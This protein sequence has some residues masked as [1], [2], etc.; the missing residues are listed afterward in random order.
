MSLHRSHKSSPRARKGTGYPF[1]LLVTGHSHTGKSSFIQTLIESLEGR[2]IM[3]DSAA[4]QA[5]K[6][7]TEELPGSPL[8][9]GAITAKT[10]V[11]L[12]AIFP[13]SDITLPTPVKARID[14]EEEVSSQKISLRIID[15]P[16]LPIPV[17]VHKDSKTPEA[18]FETKA[19]MWA[20]SITQYI[21]AQYE[22]TLLEESKVRRNPKSPDYQIHAC[23]YLLDPQICLASRGLTAL[24][25][26]ALKRLCTRV[27]VVPCLGKADLLTSKQLKSVRQFVMDDIKKNEIAIFSFPDD[28]EADY[29]DEEISKISAELRSLLPFAVINDEE[30]DPSA[31]NLTPN[32]SSSAILAASTATLKHSGGPLGRS[33]PWGTVEVENP[34]HCDFVSL[35]T[36]LFGTHIQELK[37]QTRELYY[38][39]WRT[40][41][42]LEVRGSVLMARGGSNAGSVKQRM[43]SIA[44]TLPISSVTASREE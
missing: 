10:P 30:L 12:S 29:E 24:D 25:K 36:A 23:I 27:N 13:G 1:N 37:V 4:A 8:V 34:E 40:E 19:V 38:E 35:R 41:K 17:N 42:L 11:L 26:H 33:Y 5:S 28:L 7:P 18:E 31:G 39:K 44:S 3:S 15:T 21:E 9:P 14:F 43:G 32:P 2:K 16:G 20:S 22:A 6:S